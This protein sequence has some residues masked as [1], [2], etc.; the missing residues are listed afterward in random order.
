MSRSL[1]AALLAPI[2][3]ASEARYGSANDQWKSVNRRV[4]VTGVRFFDFPHGQEGVA[5]NAV[6]LHPVFGF[7]P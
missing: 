7:K 5:A 4:T 6:E 3:L 2:I 1:G